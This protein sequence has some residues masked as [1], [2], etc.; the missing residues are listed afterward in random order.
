M[1]FEL[2]ARG[3]GAEADQLRVGTCARREALRPDVERLEQV[4]LAGPVRTD[5]EHEPGLQLELEPSIRAEISQR[6]LVDDQPAP[7]ASLDGARLEGG[8]AL[9][10][11]PSIPKNAVL[12]TFLIYRVS[13]RA[14]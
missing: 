4:R 11:R 6:D 13:P 7:R 9:P 8:R 3:L 10:V 14:G 5:H 12:S 1:S 2:H